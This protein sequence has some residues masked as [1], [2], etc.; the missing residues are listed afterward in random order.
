M[1]YLLTT[2]LSLGLLIGNAVAQAVTTPTA[3]LGSTQSASRA[4][5]TSNYVDWWQ[6]NTGPSQLI[7]LFGY[8]SG[9]QQYLQIFDSSAGPTVAVTAWV[10]ATDIFTAAAHGLTTG[11][12]VQLTG[13]VAG[14]SAGIYYAQWISAD[15][16]YLYDTL[17]HAQ[18]GGATGRS[19]V[20]GATSTATLNRLPIHTFAIAAT[21]NYSFIVPVVGMTCG[22]GIVVANSTTAAT[23]T[24]GSKNV[25]IVA[26]V[27]QGL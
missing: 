25:T 5:T 24:A 1:K 12:R 2:L 13:T 18:A 8:N 3:T 7:S 15:T 10:A 4:D 20:T 26:T 6:I 16:F 9:A 14:I 22:K 19:D 11:E 27:R 23:Y 21:D 17:A